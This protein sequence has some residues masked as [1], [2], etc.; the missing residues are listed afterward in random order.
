MIFLPICTILD[1]WTIL[2]LYTH[3]FDELQI[4][5]VTFQR[6]FTPWKIYVPMFLRE[7]F[8]LGLY[9]AQ[10]YKDL[11]SWFIAGTYW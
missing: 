1:I 10:H 6:P 11:N 4:C 7:D 3:Q 2:A 8:Y 9:E 5:F